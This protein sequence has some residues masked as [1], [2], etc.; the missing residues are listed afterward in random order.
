MHCT[1]PRRV[2]L[3]CRQGLALLRVSGHCRAVRRVDRRFALLG[4][5]AGCADGAKRRKAYPQGTS[6]H[7]RRA[8]LG[9]LPNLAPGA[10]SRRRERCQRMKD[11]RRGQLVG[12]NAVIC[13]VICDA[14]GFAQTKFDIGSRA[15]QMAFLP[16]MATAFAA[17]PI[18]GQNFG[19]KNAA[20]VHAL[21]E[22]ALGLEG[23]ERF[24]CR[25]P[26]RRT[27][28]C[29][30]GVLAMESEAVDPRL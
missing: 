26:L 18:A 20:R 17:A 19:E 21:R 30:F 5:G 23:L 28:E 16:A 6:R 9:A 3:G 8:G 4:S 24:V 7:P 25:E 13:Q 1:Q 15:V 10:S 14:G 22:F 27:H 29:V 12:F 2:R 11:T